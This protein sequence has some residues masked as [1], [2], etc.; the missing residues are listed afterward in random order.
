MISPFRS[1]QFAVR[2]SQFAVRWLR[3]CL[4]SLCFLTTMSAA[5]SYCPSTNSNVATWR[6]DVSRTGWQCNELTLNQSNVTASGNTPFGL[7]QQ[8]TVKGSQLRRSL[9]C[10]T[11]VYLYLYQP[12]G[13]RPMRQRHE[14]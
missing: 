11:G 12:D 5:Q 6:N 9:G 2:S 4:L 7:L 3:S 10:P 1:S 8:W 14:M 13:L